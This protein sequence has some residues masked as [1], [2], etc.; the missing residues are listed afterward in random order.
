MSIW[1]PSYFVKR[2]FAIRFRYLLMNAVALLILRSKYAFTKYAAYVKIIYYLK[3]IM[4]VT[5]NDKNIIF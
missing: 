3:I 4:E 1:I 2:T 5:E